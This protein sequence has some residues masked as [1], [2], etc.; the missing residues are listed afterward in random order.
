MTKR[1]TGISAEMA[2]QSVAAPEV[3][4][5]G[6]ETRTLTLRLAP[7]VHDQLREMADWYRDRFQSGVVVLGA[8]KDGK[9]VIVAAVTDDLIAR[10]LKAGDLVREVAKVVGGGGG[11]RADLATAGG[12]NPELLS[13]ALD[14]VRG[15]VEATLKD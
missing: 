2:K 8:V 7:V 13:A 1:P 15:H 12:R 6:S 9:P 10:G 5:G 11:G 14:A 3:V 4:A